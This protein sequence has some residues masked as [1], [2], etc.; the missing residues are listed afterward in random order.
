MESHLSISL[1]IRENNSMAIQALW[2]RVK[3]RIEGQ[4]LNNQCT[5]T[6]PVIN[7]S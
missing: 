2:G 7:Q 5:D 3:K 6:L 4:S 1:E